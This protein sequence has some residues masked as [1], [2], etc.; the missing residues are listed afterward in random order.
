MPL[1]LIPFLLLG[2]V[3]LFA[4]LLPFSLLQRYRM[5]RA[6]RRAI[7]WIVGLNAWGLLV[8][9][10]GY[11]GGAWISSHWV[12]ATLVWAVC[13]LGAGMV[14]GIFGLW[15]ADFEP[16]PRGLYLTPNRWL[17]L[18]LTLLVALRLADG[19]WTAWQQWHASAGMPMA[20]LLD[21]HASLLAVGGVL[22][23]YYLAFE[24]GVRARLRR[25]GFVQPGQ[26]PG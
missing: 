5:G 3:L 16:T 8:S 24:F 12:P 23:G 1:L 20:D 13:G 22:L 10:L 18:A 14:L 4:L 19:L 11:L 2:G 26:S 17:V 21:A 7:P 15:T 25:L 9:A 6:R